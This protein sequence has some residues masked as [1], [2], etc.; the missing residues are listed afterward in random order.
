MTVLVANESST[1]TV[2]LLPPSYVILKPFRSVAGDGATQNARIAVG[3][4][5]PVARASKGRA[6]ARKDKIQNAE[7]MHSYYSAT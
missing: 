3:L 6:A 1:S 7:K 2:P 4:I 5:C